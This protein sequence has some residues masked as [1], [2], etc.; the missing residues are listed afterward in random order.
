VP[1]LWIPALLYE[2]TQLTGKT[3]VVLNVNG[4]EKEG[5]STAYIQERCINLAKRG[6]LALNPEWLGRGQLTLPGM[7]HT[8]MNQ[9][10]LCGTSGLSV[11]HLSMK[12]SLD[13]LLSLDHADPERV[14]VTGLSGGGW[15]TIFLSSLDLRVRLTNP[16]AG[17]SSFVTRSQF[18]TLDLGD[19]EQ[20]PSDLASVL[21]STHLTVM[22]APRLTLLA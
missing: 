15:Q 21:D 14:A 19:S 12:R 11:F 2:P 9:L 10:D 6:I 20:T 17:Y 13:V 4:H 22:M 18:P 5:K 16:V 1:G 8:R 7:E 3:P